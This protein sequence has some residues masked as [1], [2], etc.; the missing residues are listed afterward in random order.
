M[1]SEEKKSDTSARSKPWPSVQGNRKDFSKQAKRKA[2]VP[3]VRRKDATN[4][5]HA[6]HTAPRTTEL[7]RGSCSGVATT[8]HDATATGNL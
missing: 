8:L 1:M 3:P 2:I 6:D 5:C 4:I 7:L